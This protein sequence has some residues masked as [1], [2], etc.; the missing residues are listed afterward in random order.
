MCPTVVADSIAQVLEYGDV[1]FNTLIQ[2]R[3]SKRFNLHKIGDAWQQVRLLGTTF[4]PT[5]LHLFADVGS[6]ACHS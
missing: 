2:Q 4:H 1:D 5:S 6:G 3:V